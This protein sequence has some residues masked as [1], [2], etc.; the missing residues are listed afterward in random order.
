VEQLSGWR[1]S[2]RV[3]A[4]L[5]ATASG[6]LSNEQIRDL[7]GLDA[8]RARALAQHVVTEGRL[9]TT[10]QRRGMRYLFP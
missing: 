9:V 3:D 5:T 4:V 6:L 10:G 2:G 8:A 7:T 1:A